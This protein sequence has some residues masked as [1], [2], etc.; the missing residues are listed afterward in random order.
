MSFCRRGGSMLPDE[1]ERSESMTS[2][3][4]LIRSLLAFGTL[5]LETL[6]TCEDCFSLVK[7]LLDE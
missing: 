6:A 1:Q 3:D 7:R 5:S 2:V 4:L